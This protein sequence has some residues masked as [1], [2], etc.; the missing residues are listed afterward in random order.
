MSTTIMLC[1]YLLLTKELVY[2]NAK[3]NTPFK[4]Q[5]EIVF[6]DDT[7]TGR[8]CPIIDKIMLE[9]VIPYYSNTHS[10][11]FCGTLMHHKLEKTKATI[12][13]Y[14]NLSHEHSVIFTGNGATGAV[15]HFV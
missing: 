5:I 7:A 1:H 3:I 15:N 8:P 14:Y 9:R 4:N 6:A 12:R 11:A 13:K 10:N 2:K